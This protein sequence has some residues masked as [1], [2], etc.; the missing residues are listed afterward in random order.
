MKCVLCSCDNGIKINNR[1]YPI[2]DNCVEGFSAMNV[3]DMVEKIGGD[4]YFKGTIVAVFKKL[5]GKIRVVVD[6]ED[7]ILHVFSENQLRIIV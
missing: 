5:S 7:G 3:G 6:N 1:H 4:Y 2:C